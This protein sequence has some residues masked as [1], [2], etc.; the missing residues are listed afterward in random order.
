MDDR[1]DLLNKSEGDSAGKGEIATEGKGLAFL[2][3]WRENICQLALGE[4]LNERGYDNGAAL[5]ASN[6]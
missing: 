5:T 2:F 4:V 1:K 3:R 6:R